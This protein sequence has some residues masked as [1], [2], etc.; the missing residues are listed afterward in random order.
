MTDGILLRELQ[1]DFLLTKYSIII[2]DEAHE[3]SLN[4]DLLLGEQLPCTYLAHCELESFY[5]AVVISFGEHQAAIARHASKPGSLHDLSQ[6]H[7]V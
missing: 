4:T 1:E 6:A 2:I 3:R 7:S 5:I